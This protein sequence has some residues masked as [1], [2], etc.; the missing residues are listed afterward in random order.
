MSRLRKD[1]VNSNWA[2]IAYGKRSQYRCRYFNSTN[3]FLYKI[4]YRN[5]HKEGDNPEQERVSEIFE[6]GEDS[7][8][9]AEYIFKIRVK[10][11][12]E[13]KIACAA[14]FSLERQLMNPIFQ[15]K[16]YASLFSA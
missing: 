8:P 10:I 16:S 4:Q 2:Y 6:P 3:R 14:V 1:I 15:K 13:R 5:L 7:I 12:R 9:V 11:Q